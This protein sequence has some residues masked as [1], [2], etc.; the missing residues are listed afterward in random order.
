MKLRKKIAATLAL[1]LLLQGT[2]GMAQQSPQMTVTDI[3]ADETQNEGVAEREIQMPQPGDDRIVRAYAAEG[4]EADPNPNPPGG[5]GDTSPS[6]TP[7]LNVTDLDGL[8][9]FF[10]NGPDN[11]EQPD[12]IE[13]RKGTDKQIV[14]IGSS[15]GYVTSD[16]SITKWETSEDQII[17]VKSTN[18]DEERNL[19]LEVTAN[20]IGTASL[21]VEIQVKVGEETRTYYASTQI[22]VPLDLLPAQEKE[23]INS[24]EHSS[25]DQEN[26][27][28]AEEL[29]NRYGMITKV[30]ANESEDK[31]SIQL[32]T[33]GD[34]EKYS[35]YFPMF[36]FVKYQENVNSFTKKNGEENN[37]LDL[38]TTPEFLPY[39]I[40]LGKT[41]PD[42]VNVD[43]F[44][45][46][47]AVGAGTTEVTYK[48]LD[49]KQSKTITVI[50][51]P[52]VKNRSGQFT[53]YADFV[54][55]VG[56]NSL[57][58][59][60][61][62]KIA[63][64]LRW[65]LRLKR[66]TAED[67]VKLEDNP[68]MKV[69][70]SKNDGVLTLSEM[71]AGVYYLVG[72]QKEY[73][74]FNGHVKKVY[75]RIVVPIGIQEH[76]LI[77][78]VGDT[79]DVLLNANILDRYLFSGTILD[80]VVTNPDGSYGDITT[81]GTG[82]LVV[83]Y[84]TGV[85]TAKREGKAW[86]KL[87]YRGEDK[88]IFGDTV[89]PGQNIGDVL[90]F[91]NTYYIPITVI[92]DI[93]LNVTSVDMAVGST[94]HLRAITSNGSVPLVWRTL[95]M[96]GKESNDIITVDEDGLVT[97][98]KEG[99][100]KVEVSQTIHGV[101]KTATC[102]IR[103]VGAITKIELDPSSKTIGI[104]DLLTI[105][106]K[107]TPKINSASL[108]WITSDAKIVSLEQEG[109]LSATVKGQ[110]E[111]V[112]VI[113]AINQENV[114]VGSCMVTVK[115]DHSIKKI[116]LSQTNVTTSLAEKTLVLYAT[117]TPP[118]AENEPIVWSS[119]DPSIATVDQK[120]LVTLRK[121]GTV[122]II[123][124]ARND[125]TI[126][127]SCRVTITQSVTGI[128]LDQSNVTMN[129]GETFRLTY[130]ISPVNASNP[131]VTWTTTNKSVATVD[132]N[133]LVSAKGV[134]QTAIILKTNE[135]GYMATCLINVNRVATAVRLDATSIVLNVGDYYN[136][137]T[138]IT[139]ADSTDKTLTW[140]I[141]D[142]GV[143]A[144]SN[145]GKVIAK[146]VGVAVVM[147]K[148][149]SGS[150]AYCTVTV[151]QGVTG[152]KLDEHEE[153]IFI[154]DEWELTATVSP[155][156]ATNQEVK[157]TSSD[158]SVASVDKEGRVKGL[159]EGL[160]II[161]CTT[162]DGGYIDY[163]AIQVKPNIVDSEDLTINPETCQVGVGKTLKLTPVFTPADT[164][165]QEVE[166]T[167]SDTSIVTVDAKG[168]I[169]GISVGE[170]VITCTALDDGGAEGYCEVEVCEQIQEIALDNS[171][172]DMVVGDVRTIVP[173]IRP[174]DATYGVVWESLNPEIAV[175]DKQT[176][177]VTALKAGDTQIKAIA[178]DESGVEAI[179][180]VHVRNPVPVTNI[181][182]SESEIVMIPGES[183]TV[184]FTILPSDFTDGYIWSS[185]NPV[186][187]SVDLLSGLITANAM[188]TANITIFAESGRSASIKVYV[189]G[190]SKTALTLERYTST[191]ISLEVYGASK[192]DLDV[193]WYSDNERIAQVR[194]GNITGKAL[195]TTYVYAVVNGRKLACRVTVEKIRR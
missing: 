117:I 195:G 134:G 71:K 33:P 31:K 1:A 21:R 144:V 161:T 171:Y 111:G 166:W 12:L 8:K 132:K 13:M 46:I 11:Y 61:N 59:E 63:D 18:P 133:G 49:G 175:V 14:Y 9:F 180:V 87:T 3:V 57:T 7:A 50:V 163:C 130:V 187:A 108:K 47:T 30:T 121:A 98:L 153:E 29:S 183:R 68:Y 148:T 105:N 143:V 174:A 139:P 149:K 182:V 23:G 169:K 126:A 4:D 38:G 77:M 165:N 45:Y 56:T 16:M 178:E 122:T 27:G 167:S 89:S 135:G 92:D 120:G 76:E 158:R 114:V 69:G 6:P 193:R 36:H 5:A 54:L 185:D 131:A 97:A 62:A 95:D 115:G 188:G 172:L 80:G 150:T 194:N 96:S 44:G 86:L 88:D 145:R 94:L 20:R 189:V 176:G 24:S 146:K 103:V 110:A 151:Q 35:H 152:L 104:G 65:T 66:S 48:T 124:T 53:D 186:V 74:E 41:D 179:C 138:T 75:I 168:K 90:I 72:S 79:Y 147:A 184:G 58:I 22:Q 112:A 123:C 141:S 160:T 109:D 34:D 17:E 113:T 70:I 26:K 128:K 78:N 42:V 129:V 28:S 43:D 60:T 125:S 136:F 19:S 170:A 2:P 155:K 39:A 84:E 116:T 37:L 154:G 156:N 119:S 40:D 51:A 102:T 159:K 99:T 73:E 106:A 191:L 85:L 67:T 157:W 91:K 142:K 64:N 192:S 93:A 101:T 181:A 164:T 55:Q 15:L 83:S 81:E 137:E 140:E 118:D 177:R 52:R 162:V 127:A 107:I 32:T 82:P 25:K 190:L 173:T 100:A 10:I